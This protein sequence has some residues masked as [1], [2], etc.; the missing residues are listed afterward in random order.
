[1]SSSSEHLT[2][3][4]KDGGK[5][6]EIQIHGVL[7]AADYEYFV[8]EVEKLIATHGKLRMLVE[9]LDFHG[10]TI[11]ALWED[12]KFDCKH[13]SDIERLAIVGDSSWEKAMASFCTP[14]TSA[15]IQYFDKSDLGGARQWLAMDEA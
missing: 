11:G 12:M 5:N 4:S 1:M 10:W 15:K 9:M 7:T 14:F 13:F 3:V 8:P 2:V 6:V